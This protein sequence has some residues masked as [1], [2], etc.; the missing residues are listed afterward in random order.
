MPLPEISPHKQAGCIDADVLHPS[1]VTALS[2]LQKGSTSRARLPESRLRF[3][4]P[5]KSSLNL[6]STH[7]LL[8]RPYIR[9]LGCQGMPVSGD[10]RKRSGCSHPLW[11]EWVAAGLAGG[12]FSLSPPGVSALLQVSYRVENKLHPRIRRDAE[13]SIGIAAPPVIPHHP[14]GPDRAERGGHPA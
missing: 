13:S 5:N 8:R 6:R 12:A 1:T 10:P 3:R 14:I 2:E 4:R 7:S 11:F 9:I